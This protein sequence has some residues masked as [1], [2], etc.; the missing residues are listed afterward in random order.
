M[1]NIQP[2]RLL[3]VPNL[4]EDMFDS[5]GPGALFLYYDSV[6]PLQLRCCDTHLLAQLNVQPEESLTY[7]RQQ[8]ASRGRGPSTPS[9]KQSSQGALFDSASS[10]SRKSSP[11]IDDDGQRADVRSFLS[12]TGRAVRYRGT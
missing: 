12:Q 6:N 8:G 3:P 7:V 9:R 11:E 5:Y 10:T 1:T 2:R 4:I